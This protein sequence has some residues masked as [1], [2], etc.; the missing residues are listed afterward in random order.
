MRN[1]LF[2]VLMI[3]LGVGCSYNRQPKGTKADTVIYIAPD[4]VWDKSELPNYDS[5]YREI[6]ADAYDTWGDSNMYDIIVEKGLPDS[7]RPENRR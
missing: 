3:F 1:L 6:R 4:S 5:I 7:L 2:L